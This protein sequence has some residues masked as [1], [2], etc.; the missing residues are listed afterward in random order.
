MEINVCLPVRAYVC[1]SKS[2]L[3]KLFN[4]AILNILTS[5]PFSD[6]N[7]DNR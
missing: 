2:Q 1:I 5:N 7:T 6:I 4:F 3:S